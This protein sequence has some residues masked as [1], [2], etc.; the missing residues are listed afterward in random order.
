MLITPP[1]LT[2]VEICFFGFFK[3][4]SHYNMSPSPSSAPLG[5]HFLTNPVLQ[6]HAGASPY[7]TMLAQGYNQPFSATGTF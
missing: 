7:D 2:E 6:T 4:L 3:C 1:H 5:N